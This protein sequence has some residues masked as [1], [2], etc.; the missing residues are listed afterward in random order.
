MPLS[1]KMFV[2]ALGGLALVVLVPAL[3]AA[4]CSCACVDGQ[5]K[6]ICS[7]SLEIPTPCMASVCPLVAPTNPIMSMPSLTMPQTL[8]AN[9]AERCMDREVYNPQTGRNEWRRLCS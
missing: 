1:L 2:W 3:A 6:P 5:A 9:P 8:P 4:S 7:N